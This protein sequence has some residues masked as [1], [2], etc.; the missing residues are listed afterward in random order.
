MAV[1]TCKDSGK[2]IYLR[3]FHRFGRLAHSVDTLL[4]YPEITRIHA[5]IEWVEPHWYIR[6]LS[7]NGVWLNGRKLEK[8]SKS[9]LALNDK[10]SFSELNKVTYQLTSIEPPKDLLLP[11]AN[12]SLNAIVLERYHFLPNN[13]D[14]VI[15]VYFDPHNYMWC[16]EST[17]DHQVSPLEEGQTLAIDGQQWQ[18][19]KAEMTS[20]ENTIDLSPISTNDL[21]FIFSLSLDEEQTE[22]KVKHNDGLQDFDVRSHHYLTVLLARYKLADIKNKFAPEVQGWVQV[23]KL[24]RDL[25]INECHVNIQIHRARKQFIE[26]FNN[27]SADTLIERKRG[28]VRF[29]GEHYVIYKGQACES[30]E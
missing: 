28:K 25:G 2:S 8:H 16:Y 1:L 17:D 26:S 6:D 23:K 18:L 12:D 7:K 22:L 24:A 9:Q 11:V 10:I 4:N 14:P 5:V 13:H 29:G 21:E 27:M 30:T 20:Q 19:F 15:I 3:D